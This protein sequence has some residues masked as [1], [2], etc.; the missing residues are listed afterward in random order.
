[1]F[2][3]FLTYNLFC[4][5]GT[6]IIIMKHFFGSTT[7]EIVGE[8]REVEKSYSFFFINPPFICFHQTL[9]ILIVLF[10]V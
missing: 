5:I 6:V 2:F 3:K 1:M 10:Y 4:H 7:L 8:A 9:Y